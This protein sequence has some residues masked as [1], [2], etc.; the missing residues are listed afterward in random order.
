LLDSQD[1]HHLS[2]AV[3]LRRH[4]LSDKLDP[5]EFFCPEGNEDNFIM[6]DLILGINRSTCR[7]Q[8]SDHFDVSFITSMMEWS[9]SILVTIQHIHNF[10][11]N[12]H[13]RERQ[14]L[15]QLSRVCGPL[16]PGVDSKLDARKSIPPDENTSKNPMDNPIDLF[17][18]HIVSSFNLSAN[19]QEERNHLQVTSI[20]CRVEWALFIL[21]T[22]QTNHSFYTHLITSFNL[23]TSC[24][25]NRHHF[26]MAFTRCTME[27]C[28]SRLKAIQA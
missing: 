4:D 9:R 26:C 13:I 25:Q 11:Q 24:Q 18:T 1:L 27:R 16:Q 8:D 20:R 6:T 3:A 10:L 21:A 19:R 23:C 17:R 22:S 7:E 14:S 28:S 12:V 15:H 5:K 2:T